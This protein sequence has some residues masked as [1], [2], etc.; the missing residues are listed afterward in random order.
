MIV[1]NIDIN[2]GGSDNI[3]KRESRNERV[4]LYQKQNGLPDTTGGIKNRLFAL[5][6]C[7]GV[8]AMAREVRGT[9]SCRG[10]SKEI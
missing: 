1:A 6:H 8:V 2:V 7:L 3:I 4:M 5:R 10:S 9:M